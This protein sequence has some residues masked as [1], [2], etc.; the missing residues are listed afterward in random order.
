MSRFCIG[1]CLLL[2][3]GE[4]YSQAPPPRS[5]KPSTLGAITLTVFTTNT[6]CAYNNGS[7]VVTASGGNPPYTYTCAKA[8]VSNATGIFA[9]LA[10]GTYDVEVTDANGSTASATA[11]LGNNFTPPAIIPMTVDPSGCSKTDGSITLTTTGGLSPYMYSIDD[12]LNYQAS[13]VF[14]NLGMGLYHIWVKDANG[15]VSSPW[16]FLGGSYLDFQFYTILPHFQVLLNPTCGLQLSAV[17]SPPTCGNN[18]SITFFAASGGT[19]PYLY[20]LDG[21]VFAPN[22]TN[23][24][25]GVTPGNHTVYVKDAA[26]TIINVTVSIPR[27]CP[28]TLLQTPASCGL[29]DGAIAVTQSNGIAP[30][31]YAIDGQHYQSSGNFTGLPPGPYTVIERDANGATNSANIQVLDGC[32]FPSATTTDATCGQSNGT[33]TASASGGNPPYTFSIN[34]GPFQ[35]SGIFP[36]LGSGTYSLNVKDKNTVVRSTAVTV[37][38]DCVSISAK[39][40]DASC[41]KANGSLIVTVSNGAGPY[42]YSLDGIVFQSSDTFPGLAAGPYMVKVINGVGPL[43]AA[44]ATIGDLSGPV[45]VAHVQAAT[46]AN[47]DGSITVAQ[48]GGAFP[49]SYSINGGASQDN[50]LFSGLDTGARVIVVQDANGCLAS[51]SITVPLLDQLTVDAGKDTTICEGVGGPL[52]ASSNGVNFSWS[53]TAGLSDPA[54]LDPV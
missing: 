48:Q 2:F 12:G 33:I 32:P 15:C 37:K 47:N 41:G 16:S 5:P 21:P 31:T 30:Y 52:R 36:G 50:G 23:G 54:V 7:F 38:D 42:K 25:S 8:G 20:A 3:T 1:L 26:G 17:P 11:S 39:A 4:L 13:P 49:F 43:G 18:G 19:P 6:T 45:I 34:G 22:T 29:A 44:G 10:P 46:C 14:P 40:I 51:Q 53:P 27:N 28:L 35:S 24:Y 9:D